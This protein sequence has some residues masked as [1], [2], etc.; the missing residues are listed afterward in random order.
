M[1]SINLFFDFFSLS[2][3]NVRYVVFGTALLTASSAVIGTFA[4][5]QKKALV[6]DAISHAVLP[7]ICISF[8]LC[9]NK[10][11]LALLFG[12][13]VSGWL[14]LSLINVITKYS[15]LKQDTAIALVLSTTFGFG[16]LLLTK[17]QHSGNATQMGL[18][19]FLLGKAA[20]LISKDIYTF[21]VLSVTVILAVVLCFKEMALVSFDHA[22]AESIGLPT[23]WIDTLITCLT[24]LAIVIGIRAVGIL[25]ISAMLITPP[26]A[27]RFWTNNLTKMILLAVTFGVFSGVI[28]AFISYIAPAMATGPWIVIVSSIIAYISFLFAPDTGV[29]SR[30]LKHI[31]Y[32]KK[33]MEENVLKLFYELGAKEGD[34]FIPIDIDCLM[35]NRHQQSRLL[36]RTLK[37]LKSKK[38]LQQKDQDWLFTPNGKKE[39]EKILHQHLLWEQYL[40]EYL[41]IK[42]DHVHD[43]AESTEHIIT[44]ELTKELEQSL[45][46]INKKI[47]NA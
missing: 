1:L 43:D 8:M 34:F 7:G 21:T 19:N 15:K 12:A 45:T 28:G 6:G 2:N 24:V 20:A 47:P 29:F 27:A 36:I 25:L 9:D 42:P 3:P 39:G 37:R 17:I 11:T 30:K 40:S 35:K 4:F 16:I 41:N 44:L 46:T 23:K 5:L 38:L 18:S 32:Q 26:A 31:K 10:N 13:F 22:F 33:T 14:S